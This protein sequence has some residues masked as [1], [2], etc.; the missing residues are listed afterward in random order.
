VLGLDLARWLEGQSE[1]IESSAY[2][3]FFLVAV[4]KLSDKIVRVHCGRSHGGSLNLKQSKSGL[5][6][7]SE[8]PGNAI[9][10]ETLLSFSLDNLR[11]AKKPFAFKPTPPVVTRSFSLSP[12]TPRARDYNY[13][14]PVVVV[15]TSS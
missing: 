2:G 7:S 11:L 4:D 8:G 12:E 5:F 15:Y 10:A 9:E 1:A 3:A 13:W 14:R 6:F